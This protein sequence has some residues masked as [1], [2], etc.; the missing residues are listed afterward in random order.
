ME[1]RKILHR[2]IRQD[3]GQWVYGDYREQEGVIYISN[4]QG[5]FEILPF[6]EGQFTGRF[7]ESYRVFEGDLFKRRGRLYSVI[8]DDF[9]CAFMLKCDETGKKYHFD[10]FDFST[11]DMVGTIYNHVYVL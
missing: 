3:T 2:G 8:Y 1:K 9:A 10:D 11:F 5:S 7:Y 4:E 6:S